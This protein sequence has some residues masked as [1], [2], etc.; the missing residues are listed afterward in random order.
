[1][2]ALVG[3]P[4]ISTIGSKKKKR[5]EISPA[6]ISL[7]YREAPIIVL[8]KCMRLYKFENQIV[9]VRKIKLIE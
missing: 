1:M 6:Y 7:G 9:I 3:V 5:G 8:I 2:S 4:I